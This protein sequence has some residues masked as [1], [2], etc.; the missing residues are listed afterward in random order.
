VG[1]DLAQHA[2]AQLY[3]NPPPQ[4]FDLMTMAVPKTPTA[5]ARTRCVSSKTLAAQQPKVG[6]DHLPFLFNSEYFRECL[7]D[8][9]DAVRSLA[10]WPF[11]VGVKVGLAEE[12]IVEGTAKESL[13]GWFLHLR[14]PALPYGKAAGTVAR[15]H[16]SVEIAG[17][18]PFSLVD[19]R[20]GGRE[21]TEKTDE[22]RVTVERPLVVP[23]NELAFDDDDV[24]FLAHGKL[25][26]A[27]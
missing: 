16:M 11:A 15:I 1:I 17:N 19:T 10:E 4:S 7:Y 2:L 26:L 3:C 21:V 18:A 6:D 23:D 27:G 24:V 22:D 9:R 13:Y 14:Q 12:K 8:T 20:R 25:R 5:T